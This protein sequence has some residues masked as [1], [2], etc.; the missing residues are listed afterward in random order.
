VNPISA[1]LEAKTAAIDSRKERDL[2]L[3]KQWKSGGKRP[4][5]LDPLLKAYAP[6]FN[7]KTTQWKAP[8]IPKASFRAE[9]ATQFIKALDT[10]DPNRG[11]ALNTHVDYNLRK[12]MRYVNRFQNRAYI[13]EGQTGQIG[14]IDKAH[15]ELSEEFGRPPSFA[16]IGKHIGMPAGRVETIQKARRRDIR[17]SDF[18]EDPTERGSSY[19]EQSIAVAKNILPQIFPDKPEMHQLF[20]Y[21]FGTGGFPQVTSTTE[22][23]KK[24]KKTQPQISRMKTQMGNTLKE[25]MGL[26]PKPVR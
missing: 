12:A 3:W 15:D 1:F 13:P 17:A 8:A 24:M 11:A 7:Q 19:E 5:D 22:L 20:H 21:T 9:L 4:E 6:V 25:R 2:G 26:G 14:T 18:E 23:A 16:E 10:Y